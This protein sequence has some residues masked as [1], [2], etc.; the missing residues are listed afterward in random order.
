MFVLTDRLNIFSNKLKNW[1]IQIGCLT[2]R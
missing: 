2:Y 1:Q